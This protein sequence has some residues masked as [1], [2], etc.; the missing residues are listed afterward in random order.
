MLYCLKFSHLEPI[1]EDTILKFDKE[2]QIPDVRNKIIQTEQIQINHKATDTYDDLNKM[3]ENERYILKGSDKSIG[4]DKQTQVESYLP[5]KYEPKTPPSDD[6]DNDDGGFSGRNLNR[7]FR[8]AE[9]ALN[10]AIVGADITMAVSDALNDI[11]VGEYHSPSEEEEQNIAIEE[12]PTSSANVPQ[13]ELRDR[14]RSRDGS[15]RERSRSHDSE[16]SE[17]PSGRS[18]DL[19]LGYN[20]L[21]R[22][23]SRSRSSTP[24]S[25]GRGAYPYP[26]KKNKINIFL[27]KNVLIGSRF[28]HHKVFTIVFFIGSWFWFRV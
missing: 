27:H 4:N 25:G 18:R 20:L 3:D 14:S 26:P 9:F 24:D 22:G 13:Y 8:L 23:A 7:G 19:D 11:I 10:S 15:I 2:T 28:K 6:S 12:V 5:K 16:G 1:R 17:D 21:R